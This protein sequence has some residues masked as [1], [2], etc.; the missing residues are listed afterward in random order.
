MKKLPILLAFILCFS[1]V[2]C[3]PVSAQ[4]SLDEVFDN[5]LWMLNS[6]FDYDSYYMVHRVQRDLFVLDPEDYS[7]PTVVSASVYE[8][9]LNK[10]FV[11]DDATLQQI[12]T[13]DTSIL[14]YDEES[15]TYSLY[16]IGGFGGGLAPRE[17]MCY[18]DNQD[19][20]Y[21]VYYRHV[22][23]E[24]LYEVLP[25]GIDEIEY[26][27]A[28][29]WPS[30]ITY[31][32]AEYQNGMDGY[33]RVKSLDNYG[34]KFHVSL[35]DDMTVRIISV[36]QFTES[37]LPTIKPGDVNG[38][39][40]K[41]ADDAIYL[42]YSVFFTEENYPLSQDCDFDQSGEVNAEDAIYL[43]YNVFFG[44]D[45]YPLSPDRVDNGWTDNY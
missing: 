35:N 34:H 7:K 9:T 33:Y 41:N 14:E 31:E 25:E 18:V 6:I 32:G 19:G 38:D 17:Y 13:F 24:F 27:S 45:N 12:R 44:K 10:Y 37:E 26:A 39:Y 28:L 11:I 29:G 20:T 42:L 21:N 40:I 4:T 30:T 16:F 22:T 23:Y 8:A 43:L 5:E 3:L 1:T 2:F 36:T 15:A